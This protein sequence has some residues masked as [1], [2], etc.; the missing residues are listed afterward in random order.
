M[1]C[2]CVCVVGERGVEYGGRGPPGREVKEEVVRHHNWC[3]LD[4]R[5][6]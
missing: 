4:M 2:V 5:L 3:G 1:V 6:G